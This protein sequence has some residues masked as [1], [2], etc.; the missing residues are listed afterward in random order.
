MR[1]SSF[2]AIFLLTACTGE[3]PTP[4]DSDTGEPPPECAADDDCDAGEICEQGDC[5]IGDR[6]NTFPEATPIFQEVEAAG[7]INIDGDVDYYSYAST[8]DEWVRVHTITDEEAE[9]GLDTVVAIYTAGGALHAYMDEYPTGSVTTYDSVLHAYL[10][11]AG[12]WYISVEDRSSFY[13]EDDLNSSSSF[14]YTLK[15][16]PANSTSEI[17]ELMTPSYELNPTSGTS[18]YSVGV[19]LQETGDADYIT[20]TMPWGDAPL[21]IYTQST[22]PGSAA[23]PTVTVYDDTYTPILSKSGLGEGGSAKYFD[24]KQVTYTIE[25]TDE[26]SG[27]GDDYWYVLYV[28]TRDEGYGYTREI[29]PNDD[30]DTTQ[31]LEL[32]TYETSAGTSGFYEEGLIQGILDAEGDEDWVS[33]SPAITGTDPLR[34]SILCSGEYYGSLTDLAIDITGPDGSIDQTITEGDDS[35][36]DAYNLTPVSAGTHKIR[37]YSEDAFYG[38]GA[39]YRCTFWVTDFDV[40]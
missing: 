29:E 6:D 11:A 24:A 1:L 19:H 35:T 37:I 26:L 38:P 2:S 27:G 15:V 28:R 3:K 39:Y 16:V 13:D 21:E 10:P 5:A 9:D 12:T 20:V 36:P 23:S 18:T 31:L 4:F 40:E 7:V 22:I 33:F 14:E 25:A 17:D 8:G 30:A 34:I 32:A